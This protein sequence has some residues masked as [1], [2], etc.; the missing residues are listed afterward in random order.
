[1]S[2]RMLT[3]TYM[4]AHTHTHTHMYV[5]FCEPLVLT[6]NES[7]TL[8]LTLLGTGVHP[9]LSLTP[10]TNS[11]DLGPAMVKD[12]VPGTLQLNNRSSLAIRY[13]LTLESALP[14]A[15]KI[16]KKKGMPFSESIFTG[17]GGFKI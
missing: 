2:V 4:H 3:H 6:Y 16:R 14:G 17:L 1:M 11:F 9:D 15:A 13:H 7:S 8:R 5:Q 10:D 12:T